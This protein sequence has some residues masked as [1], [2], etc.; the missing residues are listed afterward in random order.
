MLQYLQ[1]NFVR[2]KYH[3]SS[4]LFWL[5]QLSHLHLLFS[6]LTKFEMIDC[7]AF[8]GIRFSSSIPIAHVHLLR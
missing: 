3:A 5:V 7:L 2:R 1:M 8:S 4:L 6:V